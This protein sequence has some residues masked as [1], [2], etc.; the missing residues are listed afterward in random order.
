M[1]VVLNE[2]ITAGVRLPIVRMG[3]LD[4]KSCSTDMIFDWL[5]I[6]GL[7]GARLS[8]DDEACD[9]DDTAVGSGTGESGDDRGDDG[10][11]RDSDGIVMVTGTACAQLLLQVG[12]EEETDGCAQDSLRWF[13]GF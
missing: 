9:S 13:G 2:C 11:D 1:Q 5:A 6:L 4:S 3:S 8:R 10:T 12:S 7:K